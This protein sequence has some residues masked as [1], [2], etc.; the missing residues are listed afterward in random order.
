MKLILATHNA[1]KVK[2][3]TGNLTGLEI[4]LLSLRDYPEIGEIP[5]TGETLEDNALI[6]ARTVYRLTGIP[7][8]ADDTGLE[9]YALDGA[10]GIFSARWAGE[11]CRY[12]DNVKKMIRKIQPIPEKNR[13]AKFRTVMALA[14]NEG[15]LL[16]EGVIEG[17]ILSEP[18]GVCGFGYDPIFYI[19]EKQKTFAEMTIHEKGQISHRGRALEKMIG[20]IEQK[21]FKQPEI[22]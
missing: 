8:L 14:D 9:V 15:E 12:S 13:Q 20:F 2:E 22:S 10:P 4:T 16:A 18:R 17:N 3:L 19:E 21:Y 1:D 6:K 7:S 5:E 11:H